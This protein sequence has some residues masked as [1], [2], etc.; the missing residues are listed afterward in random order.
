MCFLKASAFD[1]AGEQMV[2]GEKG[3]GG[4]RCIGLQ[5]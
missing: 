5:S 4:C 1:L 2:S 3:T